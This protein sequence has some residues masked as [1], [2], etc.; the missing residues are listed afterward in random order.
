M[1]LIQKDV[2]LALPYIECLLKYWPTAN[3][4]KQRT[5]FIM[6][7]EGLECVEEI[8]MLRPYV[9]KLIYRFAQILQREHI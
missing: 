6:L 5:F 7:S 1:I 4:D 8:A 3:H 2:S 9:P